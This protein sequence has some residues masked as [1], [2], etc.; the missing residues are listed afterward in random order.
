MAPRDW[1]WRVAVAPVPPVR[2]GVLHAEERRRL[3]AGHLPFPDRAHQ[4]GQPV[5][6]T[7]G[8]VVAAWR[9]RRPGR[10]PADPGSAAG[11]RR[12]GRRTGPSPRRGAAAAR[13]RCRPARALRLVALGELRPERARHRLEGRVQR[14][15]AAA[16]AGEDNA[17]TKAAAANSHRRHQQQIR[18]ADAPNRHRKSS[19]ERSRSSP[20][21]V[22]GA[23]PE[24]SGA[25][26]WTV[27]ASQTA[28]RSTTMA[29]SSSARSPRWSRTDRSIR[30]AIPSADRPAQVARSASSRSW[31]NCLAVVVPGLEHPVGHEHQRVPGVQ[32]DPL[33][34]QIHRGEHPQQRPV[35][36]VEALDRLVV[37]Q[38][39]SRRVP[40]AA[41]DDG[42]RPVDLGFERGVDGGE[43][44]FR[45]E[46]QQ[47]LVQPGEDGAGRLARLRHRP[48]RVAG[49]AGQGGGF[50]AHP[51]H[52]AQHEAEL[53]V[54]HL[55]E[56]VE[57]A[58]HHVAPPARPGALPSLRWAG[59]GRRRRGPGWS[60][61]AAGGGSPTGRWPPG[62]ARRR[63]RSARGRRRVGST[64]RPP[65]ARGGRR[66]RGPGDGRSTRPRGR[67][68]PAPRTGA[69]SQLRTSRPSAKMP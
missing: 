1:S 12:S 24:R 57:V 66:R 17:D 59:T 5:G 56:V 15:G 52:V 45:A 8:R 31:P 33:V 58:A 51:A 27:A 29:M 44:P 35:G 30:R 47:R 37:A 62:S 13:L 49:H 60:A 19:P 41:D 42:Y 22:P 69:A 21:M 43:E 18:T 32:H 46:A 65:A 23:F 14:V 10:T 7:E 11:R 67:P 34:R 63:G 6:E 55:E 39:E 68:R 36:P 38:D 4:M 50:R 3:A 28:A 26:L 61:A 2:G 25:S 20:E 54:A 64:A 40:A 16:G 48:H 9:R 53:P